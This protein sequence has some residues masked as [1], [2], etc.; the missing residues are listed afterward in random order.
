MLAAIS[1]ARFI[2]DFVSHSINHNLAPGTSYLINKFTGKWDSESAAEIPRQ[3]IEEQHPEN[4][5]QV[6]SD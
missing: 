4:N 6:I 5:E 1:T 3:V 2:M